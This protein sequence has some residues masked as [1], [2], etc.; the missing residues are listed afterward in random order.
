MSRISKDWLPLI[1]FSTFFIP[2]A[3]M[4]LRYMVFDSSARAAGEVNRAHPAS[5]ITLERGLALFNKHCSQCHGPGGEGNGVYAAQLVPRPRDFSAGAFKFSAV[6]KGI[7]TDGELFRTIRHGLM[8][9]LMPPFKSLSDDDIKAVI[10]AVRHHAFES[11]IRQ[12]LENSP[13]RT[14]ELAE[15]RAHERLDTGAVL[16][17][18]P[19]PVKFDLEK[20][21]TFFETNC[22]VCHDKDGRGRTRTDLVDSFEQP[23]SPRDLTTGP[24]KGGD[25]LDALAIRILR[26]I[27]TTPMPA[28][29]QISAEDLWNTAAYT[30]SLFKAAPA[31]ENL[32]CPAPH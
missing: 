2:G 31:E 29:P 6:S 7:P 3:A 12:Q 28:N 30:R 11:N 1:L 25:S 24:Y 5:S 14:R 15:K 27:P 17:L 22:A 4:V 32:K 13:S 23:I 21:R 16:Q 26:G 18:P 20:G 8:P 19:R 9:S 10:L